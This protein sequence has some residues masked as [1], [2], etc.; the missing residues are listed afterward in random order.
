MRSIKHL[1]LVAL[2]AGALAALPAGASASGGFVADE[3]PASVGG[4][5]GFALAAG[6]AEEECKAEEKATLSGPSEVLSLPS[7][8]MCGATE[9]KRE[10]TMN[11]C[12]FQLHADTD[13]FDI[14]PP[15]CG[16]IKAPVGGGFCWIAI[17]SQTGLA[18]SIENSSEAGVRIEPNTGAKAKYT[19]ISGWACGKAG[20]TY[21]D[22]QFMGGSSHLSAKNAESKS[23]GLYSY[24]SGDLPV[25]VSVSKKYEK[26]ENV[27]A[28]RAQAYPADVASET[29]S[30]PSLFTIESTSD[31]VSCESAQYDAGELSG[32][33]QYEFSL[34]AEYS[35]CEIER[36]GFAPINM[37][38]CH[39][40]FSSLEAPWGDV[41]LACE[42][43]DTVEIN[44]SWCPIKIGPQSLGFVEFQ[45][46]GQG[47]GAT[48]DIHLLA[49]GVSYS[50]PKT[51]VCQ[52]AELKSASDGVIDAAL[53]LSG[54]YAG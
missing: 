26:L 53:T 23:I 28:L 19:L 38:S 24:S 45:N 5:F 17:G 7:S 11:G 27:T 46:Q 50:V 1:A 8:A 20:Q 9:F 43:E 29:E 33:A 34:A 3:Y 42:A 4:T 48:V 12:E 47:I 52:L 36:L 18:M 35:G 15:G 2:F 31:E 51:F 10:M 32:P 6:L 30:A 16:P 21:E 40:E 39:F 25:G 54:T 41:E 37:N 49:S 13:T 44:S 14:G 22:L